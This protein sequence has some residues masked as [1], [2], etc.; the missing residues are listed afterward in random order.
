MGLFR[1]V[2][3]ISAEIN[4]RTFS[5]VWPD[6]PSG[7]RLLRKTVLQATLSNGNV[8]LLI[9]LAR[10]GDMQ[11]DTILSGE[12]FGSY[13]PDPKGEFSGEGMGLSA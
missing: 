3:L 7:I 10:S 5:S 6:V 9:D 4:T 2:L 11:F 13:K 8:S 12:L 1:D